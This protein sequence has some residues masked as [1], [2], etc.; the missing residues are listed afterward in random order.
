M[1]DRML[2][3]FGATFEKAVVTIFGDVIIGATGA[4]TLTAARSKG[5]KSIVR[6]GAGDYTVQFQDK[7]NKFLAFWIGTIKGT[8]PAAPTQSIRAINMQAAGGAT[9]SFVLYN[10]AG[11]A[12]DPATGEELFLEASFGNSAAF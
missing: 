11:A 8:V 3:Q 6:N 4:P 5:I 7:Y 9:V 1:A 12:T 2:N 10:T